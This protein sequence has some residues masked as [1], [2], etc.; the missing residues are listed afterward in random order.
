MSRKRS[1]FPSQVIEFR[2]DYDG[3]LER[4]LDEIRMGRSFSYNGKP[5][6]IADCKVDGNLVIVQFLHRTLTIDTTEAK[7]NL[8]KG[9]KV[10]LV[11]HFER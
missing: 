1:E 10:Q 7:R 5:L 4:L 6:P 11:L 2:H 9:R 8:A 3:D